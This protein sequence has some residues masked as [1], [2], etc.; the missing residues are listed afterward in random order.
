LEIITSNA[1]FLLVFIP[2]PKIPQPL[3]VRLDMDVK[4]GFDEQVFKT[5]DEIINPREMVMTSRFEA[6]AAM[7]DAE[8]IMYVLGGGIS[9]ILGFIGIFNFINVM[10]VGVMAR[11][12]ELATLESVGMTKRQMRAMLRSE[13]LGYAIIT[14][15]CAMT[16]GSAITYGLF[17]LFKS[18]ADYSEFTYPLI[19]CAAVF[20]VITVICLAIADVVYNGISK[21]TLVERLREIE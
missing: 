15:A 6:R 18:A 11:K 14:I 16:L 12:R 5:L 2:E 10:S 8:T 21:M 4:D 1:F 3:I 20:A 17:L 13:G 9:A 19:P 7:R